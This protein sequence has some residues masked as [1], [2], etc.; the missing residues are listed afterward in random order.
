M[1]TDSTI[2]VTG[3]HGCIG[4]WVAKQ[5]LDSGARVICYD[6]VAE[7]KRLAMISPDYDASRLECVVGR[8]EDTVHVKALVRDRGVTHIVHLAAVLMPYCQAN[9]VEGG[10]IDVMGTLNV[11]EAARDAGRAVR[12]VYAS[13]S[14]VWGP[15]D[16]YED[17]KLTENDPLKPSTHYGV[18]KQANEGNARAFFSTNGISSFGLRPWTVYG[19]GRDV[20]LTADPTLAMKAA[21]LRQPFQIRTSGLM[22][23]QFVEDVADT[24]LAC[25]FSRQEGAFVFNLAGDVVDMGELIRFIEE[26][27]PEA[28]GLL[29]FAGPQVPVSWQMDDSQL[30]AAVP[31]IRR[32][33]LIDGIRKTIKTYEAL[34]A[35]GRLQ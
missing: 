31:G 4:A 5:A 21:A 7:P 18:F 17:R 3:A 15:K 11:F 25:L 6:A 22:D 12:I 28:R 27:R 13:S 9:P 33:S 10:M 20:G 29:T 30:R 1:T 19:P 2:L 35:A 14:A 26:V 24:F 23:L 16:A 34:A 8:I 32:T